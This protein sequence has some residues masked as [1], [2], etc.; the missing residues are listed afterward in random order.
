MVDQHPTTLL[1][2]NLKVSVIIWANEVEQ[3]LWDK[4]MEVYR[5]RKKQPES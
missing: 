3:I 4:E 5:K 1:P 2:A